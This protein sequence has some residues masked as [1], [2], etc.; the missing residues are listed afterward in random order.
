MDIKEVD[1]KPG[2]IS[3]NNEYS[4]NVPIVYEIKLGFSG[5]SVPL[6]VDLY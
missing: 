4:S 3:P 6:L 5:K 1:I 2:I